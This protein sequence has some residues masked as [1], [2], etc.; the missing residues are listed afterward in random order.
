MTPR[1]LRFA[2]F[3][4]LLVTSACGSSS[5]QPSLPAD[6]AVA[7][8]VTEAKGTVT[9]T[10]P[11]GTRTLAVGDQVRGLDV[12][13]TGPG[14]SVQI[15]LFHNDVA[16]G[17]GAKQKKRLSQS[18][19]WRAPTGSKS[20][21]LGSRVGPDRD[22]AAG[23][24]AE[25]A[26]ADTR[27]TAIAPTDEESGGHPEP[28]E[29][30]ERAMTQSS[31]PETERAPE[32]VIGTGKRKSHKRSTKKAVIVDE[33][34]APVDGRGRLSLSL[35][36]GSDDMA[37]GSATETTAASVDSGESMPDPNV[38]APERDGTAT[39]DN[40]ETSGAI[41]RFAADKK[42]PPPTAKPKV[43]AAQSL[44]RPAVKADA[45]PAKA[46]DEITEEEELESTA[47]TVLSVQSGNMSRAALKSFLK[48]WK[49]RL[50]DT[51]VCQLS[52][53]SAKLKL[54]LYPDGAIKLRPSKIR[55]KKAKKC[56]Q[57]LTA[58]WRMGDL[59]PDKEVILDLRVTWKQA[60]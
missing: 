8:E 17:L 30:E 45:K 31:T 34:P 52:D 48:R 24:Q 50:Q 46:T 5:S 18:L 1:T 35:D 41:S 20:S 38:A 29:V 26:S 9:A 55:D 51:G 33:D 11:D 19:A 23:R 43:L 22:M 49:K 13:E 60:R 27:A 15:L 53:T 44:A 42:P 4:A 59:G 39:A 12:I 47:R 28:M 3:I 37:G 10:T 56:I 6:D 32:R 21:F 58:K 54:S 7:G 57:A 40:L 16:W 25:S 14:S 36:M 2:L